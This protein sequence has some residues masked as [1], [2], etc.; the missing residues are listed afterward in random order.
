MISLILYACLAISPASPTLPY[1]TWGFWILN[2]Q[3]I[4]V[5]KFVDETCQRYRVKP[6]QIREVLADDYFYRV[7]IYSPKT[8]SNRIRA[9]R[10]ML[11]WCRYWRDSSERLRLNHNSLAYHSKPECFFRSLERR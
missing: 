6:Q 2:T 4:E 5:V 10:H 7:K 9:L 1:S 3:N 8:K 11:G